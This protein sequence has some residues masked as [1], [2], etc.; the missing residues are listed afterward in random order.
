M[1]TIQYDTQVPISGTITN[2]LQNTIL[3]SAPGP[4]V[5]SVRGVQGVAQGQLK[6]SI[7]RVNVNLINAISVNS[8]AGGPVIPDDDIHRFSVAGGE[9]IMMKLEE[10]GAVATD[11]TIIVRWDAF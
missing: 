10:T 11:P 3:E 4:G 8:R 5:Y 2:I 9:K 6:L 7:D 1:P